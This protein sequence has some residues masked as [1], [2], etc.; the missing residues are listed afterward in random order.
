MA[1]HCVG[2]KVPSCHTVCRCISVMRVQPASHTV[3]STAPGP[4]T[5]STYKLPLTGRSEQ[6][7]NAALSRS[8]TSFPAPT[9]HVTAAAAADEASTRGPPNRAGQ[10]TG[11]SLQEV[12]NECGSVNNSVSGSV[13]CVSVR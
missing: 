10:E 12:Q 13:T 8:P 4:I 9:H 3:G 2:S 1:Q 7:A 5:K 11:G 6:S